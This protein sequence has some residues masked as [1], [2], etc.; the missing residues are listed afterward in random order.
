VTAGSLR[1]LGDAVGVPQTGPLPGAYPRSALTVIDRR[2]AAGDLALRPAVAELGLPV[3]EL[4]PAELV[5]VNEP[6]D[7]DALERSAAH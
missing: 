4:D 2:L 5:N 1:A 3:V 6:A 7:L